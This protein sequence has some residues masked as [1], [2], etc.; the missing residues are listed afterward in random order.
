[1]S[2]AEKRLF[3]PGLSSLIAVGLV[4]GVACGL[5]FGDYCARLSLVGDA[6]IGLLRMTVLPYI[7]VSLV[8]NLGR[9]SLRH[10]RRLAFIGGAVLV[11]LWSTALLTIFVLGTSYPPWKSGT[12][13]TSALT[14]PP[15]QVDILSVFIP[16]NIFAALT[17]NHVPAV[18]L[19]CI[20][21]GLALSGIGNREQLIAQLDILAK[22]LVHVSGFVARLAP[23]GIFAVAASTAGTI[24]LDELVR[25]QAYIFAYAAGAL[26]L[27]FLVLPCLVATCTPFRY[28]EVLSVAKDPMIMA[29]ATGKLI[30]VLPLLI[31]QTERL[32]ERHREDRD[33]EGVPAVD[34][35]YPVAYSFPHVGKLL[36]MLFIPFAAWFLGNAMD[37]SDYPSFLVAGVC[38]YFGGPIVA[39]PFLLDLMRL[40][41]DMFQLFLLSGVVGERLGDALGAMHLVAFTLLTTSAF[42]GH[43]ALRPAAIVKS[44]LLVT[45]AGVVMLEG[46]RLTLG[47]TLDF[48]EDKQETIAHLQLLE[49]PVKS[50]VFREATPNP[51]R[52]LPGESILDRVRRRGIIRVGYNE[53]KMPF[54]YFN[55]R[56]ELVG[57]DINMAHALARDLGARIEF[58]RFSR[59]EL[60]QQLAED[61]FDVVMSG[62]VGTLERSEAMLHTA[63]YMNVTLA[64]VVPDYRARSFQSF[65]VM[66]KAERLRIGFVDLSNGFVQRL[67]AVLPR[68]ELVEL[69]AARDF[70]ESSEHGLDALLISAESGSAFTLLYPDFQVVVPSGPKVT[71]PLFYAIGNRDTEMRDF[72]EHWLDLRERDGTTR[73]YYD[74]WIL[75]KTPRQAQRRWCVMRDVLHWVD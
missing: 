18:V 10:S 52:R 46:M 44:V 56:G 37:W 48:V 65:E 26:F 71:L 36:G 57:F 20:F 4:A 58:V 34:V 55:I 59:E 7:V 73:E 9:L 67:W 19:L 3:G 29:F 6:F 74:H 21:M 14:E 31:E 54:A 75:G 39:T 47:R 53:D 49:R 66:R 2:Q 1:V 64:L 51:G 33:D 23:I 16:S 68:A 15:P 22:V 42:L 25:L 41:H 40:P 61:C 32:V 12:F 50:V 38:A 72:L 5:F 60:S 8:A 35:L 30:I 13:F 17:E 63:P 69:S 27:G 28:R 24:S 62:L 45:I 70:F 43:L 11:G